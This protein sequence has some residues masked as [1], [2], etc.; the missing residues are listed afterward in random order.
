MLFILSQIIEILGSFIMAISET[1]IASSL[2]QVEE[3]SA[4]KH[5]WQELL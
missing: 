4:G 3:P 5:L 2:V 1:R